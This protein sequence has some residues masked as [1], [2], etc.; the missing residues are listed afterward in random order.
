MHKATVIPDSA[1]EFEMQNWRMP[2]LG[3]VRR[4]DS[5]TTSQVG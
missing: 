2:G 1:V 4:M 5:D 3:E